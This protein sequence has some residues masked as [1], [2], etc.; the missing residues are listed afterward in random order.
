[1]FSTC[2]M[3]QLLKTASMVLQ[4]HLTFQGV[5]E[6]GERLRREAPDVAQR[7]GLPLARVELML[8]RAL[9][10]I[11]LVADPDP[12]TVLLLAMQHCINSRII[13]PANQYCLSCRRVWQARL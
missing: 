11:P 12:V 7:M 1:M 13:L 6:D 10:A 5:A 9:R 3:C 4:L 2:P 8:H